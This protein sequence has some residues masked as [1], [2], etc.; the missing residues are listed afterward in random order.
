MRG[1]G[2]GEDVD[3]DWPPPDERSVR[4]DDGDDFPRQNRSVGALDWFRQGS[5]SWRRSFVREDGLLFFPTGGPP[6]DSRGRGHAQGVGRAPTLM[7]RVWP[8]GE[9]LPLSIF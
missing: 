1:D 2:A 4:D 8:P 6:G 7:G 3:G 5:A 9:S